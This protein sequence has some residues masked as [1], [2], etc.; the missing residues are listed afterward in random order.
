MSKQ[1][2]LTHFF[3]QDSTTPTLL[4][5]SLAFLNDSDSNVNEYEYENESKPSLK[6]V[7]LITT[8][9]KYNESFVGYGF[10]YYMKMI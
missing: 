6:K 10:T 1:T 3:K 9:F 5:S 8:Y 7:K 4:N 2:S